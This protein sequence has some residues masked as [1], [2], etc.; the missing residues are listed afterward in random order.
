MILLHAFVLFQIFWDQLKILFWRD[1][2]M[3]ALQASCTFSSKV[4]AEQ[5]E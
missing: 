4:A 3:Q 1:E 2:R 5:M